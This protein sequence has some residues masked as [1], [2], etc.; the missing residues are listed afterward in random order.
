MPWERKGRDKQ[1][2]LLMFCSV[3]I[4]LTVVLFC[5]DIYRL[6]I[7]VIFNQESVG[8]FISLILNLTNTVRLGT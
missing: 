8:F 3:F 5:S 1:N 6:L 4:V 2:V 7:T